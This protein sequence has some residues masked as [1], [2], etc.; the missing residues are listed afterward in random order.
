MIT[1]KFVLSLDHLE[2][3]EIVDI[4]LTLTIGTW[5]V[6]IWLSLAIKTCLLTMNLYV[7]SGGRFANDSTP[8]SVRWAK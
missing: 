6:Y 3:D 4:Y 5:R 7:Y 1:V 8:L 2:T